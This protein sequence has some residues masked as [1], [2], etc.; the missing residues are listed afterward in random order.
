MKTSTRL[1]G[2]AA[3]CLLLSGTALAQTPKPPPAGKPNCPCG[4]VET[5]P[6]PAPEPIQRPTT[7]T[8]TGDTGLWFVPTADVLARGMVSVSGYRAGFNYEQG[9][10]NVGEFRGSVAFG[11]AD[12][13]ELFGALTF[14][15]RIDRDLRPV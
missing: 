5:P 11:I 9:F 6:P 7:T 2:A 12:R 3:A 1:A 15:R 4:V 10:T 14:D 8:Y 13:T